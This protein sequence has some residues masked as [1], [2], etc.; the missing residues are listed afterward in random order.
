VD[1]SD[2]ARLRV[3]IARLARRLRTSSGGG[4]TPSQLSVLFTVEA[5]GPLTPGEL[6][7]REGVRPPTITRIVAYLEEEGLLSRRPGEDR[8]TSLVEVTP[9]ARI[10]LAE[11]RERRDA[12]LTERLAK[13]SGAD[14]EVVT[15]ALPVLERLLLIDEDD[16][17]GDGQGRLS[18]AGSD[19]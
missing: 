1:A 5:R 17:D 6:A 9:Y 10:R 11:I 3:A 16:G 18:V 19:G 15:T 12:W 2:I 13:L 14:L 4:I 8:R 7:E